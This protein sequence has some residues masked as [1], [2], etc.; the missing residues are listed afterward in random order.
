MNWHPKLVAVDADGTIVGPDDKVPD[1]LAAKLRQIDQT[2]TPVVLVTGRSWLSS[3]VVLD[4][5]QIPHQYVVCNN[6]AIVATYPPLEILRK[7]TFDPAPIVEVAKSHPT[8][9]L[10][11]EAFNKG[12]N[13]SKPFPEGALFPLHGQI[14]QLSYEELAAEPVTRIIMWDPISTPEEFQTFMQKLDLAN[15]YHVKEPAN[16]LDLGSPNSGKKNGL[17]LVAQSLSIDPADI[18]AIGDGANDLDFLTYAGRGVALANAPESLKSIATQITDTYAN[19][20]TLKEL[21]LWF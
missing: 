8:V 19:N 13:V 5:L 18:L 12:Y 20:G 14:T 2:G 9:L 3:K 15:L 7:E 21:N 4:Q 17:S 16:W 11:I 10:A 1:D 6:G